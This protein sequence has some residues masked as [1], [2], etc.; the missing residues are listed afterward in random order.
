MLA[1]FQ[2]MYL[3]HFED[4]AGSRCREARCTVHIVQSQSLAIVLMGTL[5][6]DLDSVAEMRLRASL[7]MEQAFA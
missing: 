1:K 2:E 3:D 4:T 5:R 6:F 7:E